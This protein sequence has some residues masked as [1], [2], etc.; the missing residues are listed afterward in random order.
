MAEKLTAGMSAPSFTFQSVW[1]T[2]RNVEC[3]PES[4]K[5]FLFFLRYYGCTL[6]QLEI[7]NLVVNNNKFEEKG[8]KVF[9]VLQSDPQ[10]IRSQTKES[11]IPFKIICD[12]EQ[13]LYDLYHVEALKTQEEIVATPGLLAKVEEANNLKIE[14]GLYEGNELQ[15]PAVFLVNNEK[16]I[17]F[18]HYG[19]DFGDIP[20]IDDLISLLG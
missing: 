2:D 18:A 15:L 12:P 16:V 14:H 8:V 9:V 4:G 3:Y 20:K 1:S 11:D 6:C 7:H 10:T 13:S 17:E 5:T 19:K